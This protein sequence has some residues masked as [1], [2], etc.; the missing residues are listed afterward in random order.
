MLLIY[1]C[2]T[3]V[4]YNSAPS[5]E[6]ELNVESIS[7]SNNAPSR[8]KN[9]IVNI[10]YGEH[11]RIATQYVSV[12]PI[13]TVLSEYLSKLFKPN[14]KG[15]EEINI[16]IINADLMY[17]IRTADKIPYANMV[18]ALSTRNHVCY[19]EIEVRT[20]KEV[21]LRNVAI[22]NDKFINWSD[23]SEE[24]KTSLL[25]NCIKEASAQIESFIIDITTKKVIGTSNDINNGADP[26]VK[27]EILKKLLRSGFITADEYSEKRKKIL[28]GL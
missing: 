11:L 1:G 15:P 10:G 24:S 4:H 3:P 6:R 2:A 26:V 21:S 20:A 14:K 18:S 8:E 17:E 27:M 23:L 28:D 16:S 12:P 25:D 19:F 13:S 5:E 9:D 7:I 22:N